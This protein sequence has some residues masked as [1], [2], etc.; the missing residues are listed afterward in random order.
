[1]L[2]LTFYI[3]ATVATNIL[4]APSS[5]LV[6]DLPGLSWKPNFKQYSG[7]LD[8]ERTRHLHYWF[9]ESS[10]NPQSDP[11]VVWMNGG[12]GCS[13]L[14]GMLSE[15]GPFRVQEDGKT[16]K[17]NPFAWNQAANMIYLEAPAGVGFSYADDRNYTTDDDEVARNNHLA[18][19]AFFQKFPEYQS[20]DFYIS[21]E[22]YG[23][24]YVPTL[25]SNIIDDPSINL[26]GFVVG[27]GLSD[28]S[29][30]D[31]SVIYFAYYHGL[32]GQVA[33][34]NLLDACC[35]NAGKKSC[36]FSGGAATSHQCARGMGEIQQLVWGSG[37]NVYNLYA[38]CAGEDHTL[39]YDSE[40]NQFTTSRFLY[41][42]SS[43]KLDESIQTVLKLAGPEKLKSSPPCVDSSSMSKFLNT[44]EVREA[45]HISEKAQ[46][47]D[48]CS[49]IVGA[50]YHRVYTSMK[51]QYQ[52]A[53]EHKLR[54]MVYNGDVDMACNFLGDE[55]FVDSL[56]AEDPQER[57]MWNYQAADG[58]KQI[59]GFFKAF[60][61]ITFV[62]V[63]GAG[64]MVPTDRPRPALKMFVSFIQN[65]PLN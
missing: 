52:K 17:P 4:A 24:I 47:W 59:A 7:Y 56:N 38:E 63:R 65:T 26:K 37:L 27:N 10:N 40:S 43:L 12:P 30:N 62:T 23:G 8:T 6:T 25:A 16:L 35:P 60:D 50:H 28:N 51:A 42:F 48:I 29:L 32:I 13:S 15:H 1:M 61:K 3:F 53:L 45:L 11:V 58:T 31:N 33:W 21:G 64:H 55:W 22:S 18:I 41:P 34:N 5:D 20:H 57:K 36:D 49:G 19:K 54:I 9:V 14:D 44:K 2:V 46:S 39:R